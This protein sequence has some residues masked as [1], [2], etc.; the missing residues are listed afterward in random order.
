[1]TWADHALQV[2]HIAGIVALADSLP[3]WWGAL[4]VVIRRAR[5]EREQAKR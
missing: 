4:R 2:L 1:M 3:R 5:L